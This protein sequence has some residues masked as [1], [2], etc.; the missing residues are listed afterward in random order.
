M[1]LDQLKL[2]FEFM[3]KIIFVSHTKKYFSNK[4]YFPWIIEHIYATSVSN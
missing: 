1:E 4:E 2:R 3:Y